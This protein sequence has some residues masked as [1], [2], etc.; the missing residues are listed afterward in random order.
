MQQ[1]PP[2]N[3]PPQYPYPQYP[4]QQPFTQPPAPAPKKKRRLLWLWI[5]IGVFVVAAACAGL[6]QGIQGANTPA[7]SPT[8]A[9]Q[10]QA[11]SAP[12]QPTPKPL[13]VADQA[14]QLAQNASPIGQIKA[15]KYDA[16]TSALTIT[17]YLDTNAQLNNSSIIFS[18]KSDC[19]NIQQA[20]WQAHL[21]SVNFVLL[22]ITA[23]LQDQF[24]NVKTGELA[25]CTLHK[26]TASQFN[27][28][29]LLP[30]TAWP[31]YDSQWYL[32]SLNQ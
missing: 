18:I 5:I 16:T 15:S 9:A 28:S 27:W 8:Q 30:D 24:G 11:T 2:D 12:A 17:E 25:Y 7:S 31:V 6:V 10:S 4:Q 29:N 32:P 13:S 26:D 21:K 23:P 14:K 20:I 3:Q 1:Y 22:D 19:F